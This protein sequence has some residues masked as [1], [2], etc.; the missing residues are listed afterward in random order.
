M[1]TTPL[2]SLDFM[3]VAGLFGPA[4]FTEQWSDQMVN[5][6]CWFLTVRVVPDSILFAD[7]YKPVIVR[8]YAHAANS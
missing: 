4:S 5:W 7:W 3:E 6:F 8:A 1:P 2:G